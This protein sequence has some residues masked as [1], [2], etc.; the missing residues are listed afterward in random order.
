MRVKWF[1]ESMDVGDLIEVNCD[2]L[3][4]KMIKGIVYKHL[5]SP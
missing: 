3:R 2:L 1:V 5:V 4:P